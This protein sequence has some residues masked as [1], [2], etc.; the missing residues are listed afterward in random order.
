MKKAIVAMSGG[1][2][3][4][5][6]AYLALKEG[7]D[8]T[9]ITLKLFEDSNA[10][11]DAEKS[12]KYLNIKWEEVDYT[13]QFKEKVISYFVK[14]YKD[15]KTP[16]PCAYCNKHA[17][18]FFLFK[19]M[20]SRDASSIVTGHYAR[21]ID[22]HGSKFLGK[23][24]DNKKD[25][26][27]YLCLLDK[28]YISAAQFPNGELTKENI[29]KRSRELGIPV[30][31]KKDSQEICFLKGEKYTDFLKNVFSEKKGQKGYFICNGEKIKQHEGIE[32]YTVGQRKGLNT[33]YHKTLYVKQ[34]DKMSNNI[35]LTEDKA[36]ESRHIKLAYCNFNEVSPNIRRVQVSLRYRMK[37]AD[38]Y[39]D[40]LPDNKAI[41][42]FDKAQKSPATG[43]VAAI[44][45]NDRVIGGG[46]IEEVL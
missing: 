9:G 45:E 31:G 43:Q 3:S 12:A 17:K 27:Y 11:I 40:I 19:E 15:G 14:T 35:I 16:N 4:T 20:L 6:A 21:I 41:I 46:F 25:Q 44:Y 30:S 1:V 26:S 13:K 29:R 7:Y 8:V 33:G 37:P 32:F 42:L 24:W 5:F 36:F 23:A 18:F 34:I 39:I 2:D 10:S 38:C 22:Y 28:T